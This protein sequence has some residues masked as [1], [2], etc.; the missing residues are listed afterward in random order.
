LDNLTQIDNSFFALN[1]EVNTPSENGQNF[2]I[3]EGEE[4]SIKLK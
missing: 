4:Y 3:I 1:F 2:E